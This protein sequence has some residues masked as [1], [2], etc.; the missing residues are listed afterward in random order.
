LMDA[1][2]TCRTVGHYRLRF[3]AIKAAIKHDVKVVEENPGCV[4]PIT[5][6]QDAKLQEIEEAIGSRPTG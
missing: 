3:D 4:K 2:R 1:L 5:P 6:E